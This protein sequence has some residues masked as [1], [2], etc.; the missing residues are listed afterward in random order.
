MERKAI[1]THFRNALTRL[2]L[3]ANLPRQVSPPLGPLLVQRVRRN[4]GL[5]AIALLLAI[6]LWFFVN[7]GQRGVLAPMRV[8]ISY[9]QLPAGL[10]IVNQRPEFV[11]IEVRGPRTLLSLLDPDRM[12]LRLDLSGVTL[13]QAVFKIGPEMFNVPRQTDVTRISPSQIVLDIDR[14]A[15]RQ[16]P[17]HVN[18]QGQPAAG[19]RVASAKANPP[20]ATVRGPSRFVFHADSV[21]TSPVEVNGAK[22]DVAQPVS[23]AP[24]SDRVTITGPQAAEAMVSID[25]IIADR[26]FRGLAVEV[27]DTDYKVKTEPQHI[28]VTVRGPVNQLSGLNLHGS[29]YVTA[30]DVEPGLRD[31]PV[32]IE[33]PDGIQLVRAT[34]DNVRVRI[35]RQKRAGSG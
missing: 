30:E 33:L 17:I 34:P 27:R 24:P 6:G 22:A 26:E 23:L 3:G 35:Y 2:V 10:V 9:R 11:Q 31:L 15:D 20:A 21:Q 16:I 18:V 32:Q 29:V 4:L 7:A 12:L 28:A 8:P 14:I 19:Y 13:G 1:S 5:R 25:E